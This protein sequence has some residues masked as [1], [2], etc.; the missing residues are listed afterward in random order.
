L[1]IKKSS[2][3]SLLKK[4]AHDTNQDLILSYLSF[5]LYQPYVVNSRFDVESIPLEIGHRTL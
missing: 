3:A 5:H 1:Y 4:L 2:N